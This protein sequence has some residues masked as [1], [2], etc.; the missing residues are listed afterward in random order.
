MGRVGRGRGGKGRGGK[1]KKR[2]RQRKGNWMKIEGILQ[3]KGSGKRIR[4]GNEN[5]NRK[6]KEN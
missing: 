6:G 5:E 2:G 4:M 1:G 3:N